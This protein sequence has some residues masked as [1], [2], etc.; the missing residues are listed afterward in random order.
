MQNV[1]DHTIDDFWASIKI[2]IYSYALHISKND[3]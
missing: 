3:N 1:K 2:F